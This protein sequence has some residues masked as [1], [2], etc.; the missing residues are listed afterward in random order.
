MYS[1]YFLIVYI[2]LG[3]AEILL[4]VENCARRL[5]V[6]TCARM[7][8]VKNCARMLRVHFVRAWAT[9][10]IWIWNKSEM[11][12]YTCIRMYSLQ[13][14][15][16]LVMLK[17]AARRKL[18]AHAARLKSSAQGDN[19]WIEEF[20]CLAI[21]AQWYIFYLCSWRDSLHFGFTWLYYAGIPCRF[22]C[23]VC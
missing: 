18:R 19:I 6:E 13:F 15:F 3:D 11:K 17:P 1:L 2:L 7:L 5:R 22:S 9:F 10:Q 23:A 20:V 14:T 16:S 21:M 12:E 4:R 8:R